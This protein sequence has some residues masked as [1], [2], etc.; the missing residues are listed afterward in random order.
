MGAQQAGM[1]GV[2]MQFIKEF[3]YE[4]VH[5]ITDSAD[6]A[7]LIRPTFTGSNMEAEPLTP[8]YEQISNWR[9]LAHAWNYQSF[10]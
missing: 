5:W 2:I 7:A 6:Y 8:P 9:L 1:L 4:Q 10:G 3:P